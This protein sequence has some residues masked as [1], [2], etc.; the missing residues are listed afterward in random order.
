MLLCPFITQTSPMRMS[1]ISIFSSPQITVSLWP[2]ALACWA[3]K[4]TSQRPVLPAAV[5]SAFS[6]PNWTDTF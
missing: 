3:G 5:A 6:W 4:V 2:V 1:S